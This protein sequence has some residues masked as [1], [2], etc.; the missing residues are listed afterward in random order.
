MLP[1]IT[2]ANKISK[3]TP[4]SEYFMMVAVSESHQAMEGCGISEGIPAGF[5][6]TK[7]IL[8]KVKMVLAKD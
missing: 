8:T 1:R 7:D 6:V 3:T 5:L 4:R 2:Q